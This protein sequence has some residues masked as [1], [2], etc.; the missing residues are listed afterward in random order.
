MS[1]LLKIPA[2][3]KFDKIFRGNFFYLKKYF[4]RTYF[5]TKQNDTFDPQAVRIRFKDYYYCCLTFLFSKCGEHTSLSKPS[6][7]CY[8][9]LDIHV[10][11]AQPSNH[12]SHAF[13]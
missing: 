9:A 12:S 6:C 8:V 11:V 1:F 13:S 2:T 3:Q 4:S 7:S 10:G 5:C